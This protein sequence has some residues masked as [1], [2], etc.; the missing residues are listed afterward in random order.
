MKF[1]TKM[2]KFI[3]VRTKPLMAQ[4]NCRHVLCIVPLPAVSFI[5]FYTILVY[6]FFLCVGCQQ[7]STLD[8]EVALESTDSMM[9]NKSDNPTSDPV[10]LEK[11]DSIVTYEFV[12]PHNTENLIENHYIKLS[13]GP[14]SLSGKYFGT[15]DEFDEAREGY[16][17]GFFVATMRNLK[18][19]GNSIHFSIRCS[20]DDF[21]TKAI[22]LTISN[23]QEARIQG[24]EKWKVKLGR[25]EKTYNGYIRRD[26]ILMKDEYS[27]R[28]FLMVK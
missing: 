15:T 26:T 17:P 3:A 14:D 19:Q 13:Y 6:W 10:L 21:F 8:H 11:A 5:N 4:L 22:G 18:V 1:S 24:Y 28:L 12:Y 20:D 9:T 23:S 16:L 27:D 2:Q 7:K 25:S